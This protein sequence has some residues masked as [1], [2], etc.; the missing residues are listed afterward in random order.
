[1]ALT[2]KGLTKDLLTDLVRLGL[3]DF[4]QSGASLPAAPV[5]D[6]AWTPLSVISDDGITGFIAYVNDGDGGG[7]YVIMLTV[8]AD[9]QE[10]GS[11]RVTIDDLFQRLFDDFGRELAPLAQ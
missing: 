11:R 2:L 4:A 6:P 5:G 8:D 1:M 10:P 7:H 9:D 3:D